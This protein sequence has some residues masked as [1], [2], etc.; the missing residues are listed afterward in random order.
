MIVGSDARAVDLARRM[1]AHG[2]D[3]RAIR[4]PTVPEG[5]SR[6]RLALTLNNQEATV[7][8]MIE[9]LAHELDDIRRARTP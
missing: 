7:H 4:P 6:L 1:Q 3:I 8:R 5:T 2:Y 9:T